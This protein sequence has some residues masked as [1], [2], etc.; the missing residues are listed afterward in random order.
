MSLSALWRPKSP[1]VGM[2]GAI[3]VQMLD[4]PVFVEHDYLCD[5]AILALSDSPKTEVI[6]Y[7]AVLKDA[8]DRRPVARMILMSRLVKASSALWAS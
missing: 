1:Y 4:G 5:G 2:F 3:E 7:E 8:G 6:W